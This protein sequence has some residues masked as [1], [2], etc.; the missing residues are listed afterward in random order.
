MTRI[1]AIGDIHGCSSAFESILRA[2]DPQPDDTIITLGDYVDKGHDSKGVLD[3][4]IELSGRCR[5]VPILGNHEEQM[6]LAKE[7]IAEFKWWMEFGGTACLDS[8]GSSGQ[9]DLI[10]DEHF[11]FLESCLPFFETDTH[12]FVHGNYDP[13]LTLDQ[14]NRRTLRWP[15][16]RDSVPGPHRSGKI[17]VVGHTPQPEILNLG[18]LVCLDT[19]CAYGGKLTAME[20][21]SGEVWQAGTMQ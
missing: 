13:D 15:S 5:L 2:I 9:I 1:I 8:Y 11:K 18:H 19:G 21:G 10:P 12:F 3:M 7:D 17:A 20:M 16:L 6:L 14:Q 4:L